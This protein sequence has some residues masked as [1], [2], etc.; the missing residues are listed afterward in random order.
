VIVS[1]AGTLARGNPPAGDQGRSPGARVARSTFRAGPK[2][3]RLGPRLIAEGR[4][5]L[6]ED[7]EPFLPPELF[8][9]ESR[10][11]WFEWQESAESDWKSEERKVE[12][13]RRSGSGYEVVENEG[14]RNILSL[15]VGAKRKDRAWAALWLPAQSG[16]D[17]YRF[18]VHRPL[19]GYV[20]SEEF[21]L[22]RLHE[23]TMPLTGKDCP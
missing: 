12:I 1:L 4:R 10:F 6:F 5:F 23:Y 22:N 18:R 8:K 9:V 17:S 14:N 3:D 16:D 15:L 19:E 2:T 20:C 13:L 11:P 21:E 7:L